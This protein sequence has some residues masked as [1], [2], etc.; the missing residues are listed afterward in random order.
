MSASEH[1]SPDLQSAY[2]LGACTD[3]EAQHA[4]EHLVCCSA[5]AQAVEQL[6]PAREALLEAAPTRSAP[7]YLKQAVMAEVRREAELFGAV[8]AP[9]SAAPARPRVW[10]RLRAPLPA[11]GL[12]A[13]A[14]LVVV[15]GLAGSGQGPLAPAVT[16]SDG[17][18]DARLAPG[19]DARI[20]TVN[21]RVR[22]SVAGLPEAGPGR[23]YQVW[24]RSGERPPR[25]AR[26][27]FS[28][29]ADGS[30]SVV[31]PEG[32]GAADAV[33]VTSEPARGSVLPSREPIAEVPA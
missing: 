3:E 4:R 1:I 22:L 31:L 30:A 12:A 21:G 9:A 23:R 25:S 11:L 24:L 27:L 26:L 17:E 2:V 8:E 14:A 33:L 7:A 20:E 5:C 32:T 16:V 13:A 15:I 19:G 29:D 28:V 10:Q 6:R 18:V